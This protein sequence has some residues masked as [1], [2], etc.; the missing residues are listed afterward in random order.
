MTFCPIALAVHCVGCPIV[1]VCPAKRALG[2]YGT[3]VPT[4]VVPE[5]GAKPGGDATTKKADSEH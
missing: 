5:S 4:P 1:K 2:D 3:Y